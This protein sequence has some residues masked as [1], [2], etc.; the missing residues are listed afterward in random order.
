MIP[1]FFS[2]LNEFP[3]NANGKQDRN[4]LV[5]PETDDFRSEYVPPRNNLEARICQAMERVLGLERIG[6]N[7][8]FFELGG[9]SLKSAAL[10][11]EL[12]DPGYTYSMIFDGRTPCEIA[13]LMAKAGTHARTREM[14][15]EERNRP[16]PLLPFQTYYLDYQLYAPKRIIA[17]NPL[18]CRLP[19]DSASPEAVR[20]A[21]NKV[22]RH[23]AVFGTVFT[24]D[25]GMELVQQYEPS[26]IPDI[27][28]TYVSEEAFQN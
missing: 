9:D 7:D 22:F 11:Q 15:L 2:R 8:D 5:M 25:S 21:L 17:T 14:A 10:L 23:F 16:Q 26:L 27:E 3:K 18:Y 20:E 13:S 4:A 12:G 19:A 6:V 1:H 28:I 24:F